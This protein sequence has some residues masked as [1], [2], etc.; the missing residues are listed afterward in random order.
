MRSNVQR[1]SFFARGVVASA[2][3][4]LV[5]AAL[6]VAVTPAVAQG[7]CVSGPVIVYG[8][9]P[10]LTAVPPT[11]YRI[12]PADARPPMYVVNQGP[13]YSGPGIY[14]V[15]TFSERGY[16]TSVRYPYTYGPR[17]GR[18]FYGPSRRYHVNPPRRYG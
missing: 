11:G 6:A 8:A 5:V 15:P 7:C 12:D 16:G 13:V 14:S 18:A 2:V 10:V 4:G 3:G 9:V 1:R 17:H